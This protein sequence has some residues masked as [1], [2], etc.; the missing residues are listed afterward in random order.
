MAKR[1]LSNPSTPKAKR[2]RLQ[3]LHDFFSSPAKTSNNVPTPSP[4]SSKLQSEPEIIDVDLLPSEDESPPRVHLSSANSLSQPVLHREPLPTTATLPRQPFPASPRAPASARTPSTSIGVTKADPAF[5]QR[6]VYSIL[7]TDT[8][9]F[10]P[11][12]VAGERGAPVQ[13]SL[14]AHT[15]SLL[16]ETRSRITILNTLT[17]ALRVILW[18][19]P[20]SLLPA[21]YLLSNTFSPPYLPLELGIGQSIL[22]QAIMHVSGLPSSALKKLYTT[23]GDPG[24]VAFAAKSK[25]QT[26][27]P[28]PPLLVTFVH[29][30]F[31]KIANCK[32]HGANKQK[33]NIIERLLV[34]AKGEEVRFLVRA[35]SLNLRV[36]AVR[37]SILTA[38]ARAMVLTAPASLAS[39]EPSTFCAS[40]GLIKR[41]KPITTKG[42]TKDTENDAARE[43]LKKKFADAEALIRSVFV[44]HPNYEDI[45]ASLIRYG[46]DR[47]SDEVTLTVGAI[48]NLSF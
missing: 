44:Q 48:L 36:G 5:D 29:Q 34:A 9:L 11:E 22:T 42:K 7:S 45:T 14:L 13:Y 38:L 47:L 31:I 1:S 4:T 35:L 20:E 43:E 23:T 2:E 12:T 26:L 27:V 17:N 25:V 46:L 33:Q 19:H 8:A 3:T 16:S 24:D 39:C 37:T 41:V 28:H 40:P 21:I 18:Q 6:D 15:L 10:Q 32:G 30:S